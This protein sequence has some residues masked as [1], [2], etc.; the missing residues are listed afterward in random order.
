MDG[1]S[2]EQGIQILKVSQ[3]APISDETN[4]V[5]FEKETTA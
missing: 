4:D 3:N 1:W 2:T 5:S